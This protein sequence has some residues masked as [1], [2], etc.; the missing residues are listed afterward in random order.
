MDPEELKSI[1]LGN[2]WDLVVMDV[3]WVDPHW[4]GASPGDCDRI[5]RRRVLHS[6]PRRHP[7][8]TSTVSADQC[9]SCR[10]SLPEE[11]RNRAIWH[12]L[13]LQQRLLGYVI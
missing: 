4:M 12:C 13:R 6:C 10:M 3:A 8:Y 7:G 2:D 11:V 5:I 9:D 1:A